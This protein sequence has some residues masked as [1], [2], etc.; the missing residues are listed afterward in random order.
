MESL[1]RR[2]QLLGLDF[3]PRIN[4]YGESL[5]IV[6]LTDTTVFFLLS[7]LA[8]SESRETVDCSL[9]VASQDD[10]ALVMDPSI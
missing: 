5:N 9:N 8:G 10:K 2:T 3:G 4:S 1:R 6:K 7:R